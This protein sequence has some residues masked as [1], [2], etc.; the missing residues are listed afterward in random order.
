MLVLVLGGLEG[1]EGVVPVGLERVGDE[2][3]VGID[4]EVAA[5]GELGP[6]A[7]ALDVAAAE[8]VG[9]V[10]ARFQLGLDGERDLER[11]RGDRVEQQL[12]DRGVD[13]VAGDRLA[14]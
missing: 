5:A 10:G 14:A 1:A 4:G 9:F 6:L 11:E 3:V 8:S 7:G 12:A 2:P 13:A